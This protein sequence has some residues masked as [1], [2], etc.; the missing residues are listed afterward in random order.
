MSR[1]PPHVTDHALIRYLERVVGVDVERYRR[2]VADRVASAVALGATAVV[3]DGFRYTLAES[4]VTTVKRAS[5][6]RRVPPRND[7]C[8]ECR[9]REGQLHAPG[10]S[11]E[12][13]VE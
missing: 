8:R 3:S 2:D 12:G 7:R 6:D 10:C 1:Q 4:A 9:R 5:S 11:L 13:R